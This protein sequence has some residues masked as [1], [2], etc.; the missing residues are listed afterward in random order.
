V[1]CRETQKLLH[2]YG[3]GELDLVTHLAIEQHLR[4]CPTCTGSFESRR[5]LRQALDAAA[6]HFPPP[7]G[8]RRRIR[9]ALRRAAG[10][11]VL[12]VLPVRWIAA[13]AAL[14]LV[15]VALWGVVRF[16]SAPATDEVVVQQI[17]A[18]HVRSLMA[19]QGPVEV[20]SSKRHVVK[21][22]FN[23][24]L[25]YSPPVKDLKEDAERRF[26]LV[27]GRRDYVD[28]RPV[29]ALVYQCR[30]HPINLFVWPSARETSGE[31]IALTRQGYHL[32]HWYQQGAAYW[33]VSDLN[34]DELRQFVQLLRE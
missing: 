14:A 8:L 2:A 22:W 1:D 24:K 17:L 15:A 23:G 18:G 28:G 31:P 6:L 32:L 34:P 20:A 9:S 30:D 25:D 3:D 19:T 27:G 33:V 26:P 11:S 29:A 16:W 7:A 10:R 21:P 5:S 12:T 4:E 13:V